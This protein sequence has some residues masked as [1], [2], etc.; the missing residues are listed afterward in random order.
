MRTD[1]HLDLE[2]WVISMH[3][4]GTWSAFH[5]LYGYKAGFLSHLEA[6]QWARTARSRQNAQMIGEHGHA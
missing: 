5:A 1:L 4:D 6:S 3:V 2:P